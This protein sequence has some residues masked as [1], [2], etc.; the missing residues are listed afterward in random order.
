MHSVMQLRQAELLGVL[1]KEG[2][3]RTL[4]FTKDSQVQIAHRISLTIASVPTVFEIQHNAPVS[5]LVSRNRV[6]AN[7]DGIAAL[8]V[9]DSPSLESP[10]PDPSEVAVPLSYR[11]WWLGAGGARTH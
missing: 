3:L 8:H 2:I 11:R 1:F 7:E 4:T 5:H 9:G 6:F 10:L